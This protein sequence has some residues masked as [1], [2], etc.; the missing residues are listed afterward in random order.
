MF[1]QNLDVNVPSTLR[2]FCSVF[3]VD[4]HEQRRKRKTKKATSGFKL[5]N[6]STN[7]QTIK[8]GALLYT[9]D[10]TT[11]QILLIIFFN[12]LRRVKDLAQ[13]HHFVTILKPCVT[14]CSILSTGKQYLKLWMFLRCIH[15]VYFEIA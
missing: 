11:K 13:S 12:I 8:F 9:E 10:N 5:A 6:V 1:W 14:K 7:K 3:W 4:F 2:I 15:S